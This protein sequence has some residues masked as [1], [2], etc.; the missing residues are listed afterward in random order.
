MSSPAAPKPGVLYVV[1]TPIG[2][3]EDITLRALRVLREA[4][5][6]AAEDTRVTRKLLSRYDIHTPLVSCSQH[7]RGDRLEQLAARM[8]A[9]E[10]VALVTDAGTPGVSDPGGELIAAAL[11]T[12]VPVVPVPGPSAVLAALT[13]SGLPTGRFAFHGFPPRTRT[14][15]REFFARL[16]EARETLVLFEAPTRLSSTLHELLHAL[17]D[18]RIAVARELTKLHE[19][20]F[21]GRISEAVAQFAAT[22][23]RGELTLVIGPPEAEPFQVPA[24]ETMAHALREELA[25][26]ASPRDSVD[27]VAAALGVPRRAVY[28]ALLDLRRDTA[29]G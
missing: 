5:V 23:P 12:G 2:N 20:V 15:R 7:A 29:S 27:R 3:L 21:R 17:G 28:R 22:P 26:G 11:R 4:A 18:R 25:A 19:E 13:V 8:A 6:I 10:S 9:G 24:A 16:Q 14:D 1:G